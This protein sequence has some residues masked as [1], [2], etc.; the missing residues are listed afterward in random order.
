MLAA[1]VQALAWIVLILAITEYARPGQTFDRS[2]VAGR[3]AQGCEAI[4]RNL[5]KFPLSGEV[6]QHFLNF[7]F[8]PLLDLAGRG[9]ASWA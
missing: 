9:V 7:F 1:K 5:L 8:W 2:A 6:S 4:S 3:D